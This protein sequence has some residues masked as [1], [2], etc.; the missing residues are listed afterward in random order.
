MG[1]HLMI[2]G[3]ARQSPSKW[4]VQSF[5]EATPGAIGMTPIMPLT[6]LQN[7]GNWVGIQ[8]IAE[9]HIAI[10]TKGKQVHVDIFSCKP[11]DVETAIELVIDYLDLLEFRS[12]HI[13]RTWRA[14]TIPV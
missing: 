7:G 12:Q 9:S 8:V 3:L 13:R 4:M 10:H 2:D 6:I 1:T 5:L 14:E 11:F